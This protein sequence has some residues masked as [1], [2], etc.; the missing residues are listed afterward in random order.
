MRCVMQHK[1]RVAA[2]LLVIIAG[3]LISVPIV[4]AV[5]QAPHVLYGQVAT[6]DGTILSAGLSIEARINNIHYG[7]SVNSSTNVATQTTQ[8][9]ATASGLNYGTL[10]N[11]Q[12]CADDPA[13][14]VVEGG[15]NGA[16]IT[17]YVA[18]IEAMIVEIDGV[19]SSQS[20]LSLSLGATT[21]LHLR[22]SSL[23]ATKA[24]A[25]TASSAAC[26]IAEA[27]PMPTPTPTAIPVAIATP[28]PTPTAIPVA[29]ATPTPTPAPTATPV[30]NIWNAPVTSG[31]GLAALVLGML[32]VMVLALRLTSGSR[33][34]ASP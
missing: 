24:A 6:Q 13:T 30:P 29:T 26:G 7:Q 17:F 3:G 31:W 33:R 16:P 9:H 22:I 12:V 11:F 1:A 19:A 21:K 32:V 28:T 5:P 25:A 27:S 2:I 18:G 34:G 8:T 10:A 4:L 15:N 23:N 20:S 14:T